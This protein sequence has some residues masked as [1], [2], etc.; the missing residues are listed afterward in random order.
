[1]LFQG[2]SFSKMK[3]T[4]GRIDPVATQPQQN[5]ASSLIIIILQ[6]RAQLNAGKTLLFQAL[7]P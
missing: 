5:K 2:V 6:N 4:V 3:D 1:M 7:N